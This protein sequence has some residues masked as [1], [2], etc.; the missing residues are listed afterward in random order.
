MPNGMQ[1]LDSGLPQFTGTE[2]TAD[3]VSA[4]QNYLFM[5]LEQLRYVLNNLGKEN[6]NSTE[7][8]SLKTEIK[9]AVKIELNDGEDMA[10]IQIDLAGLHTSIRNAEGN[11]STLEQTAEGIKSQVTDAD[12]NYTVLNLKA[13]GLHVGNDSG[14]TN[15]DGSSINAGSLRLTDNITFTNVRDSALYAGATA[16]TADAIARALANGDTLP[17]GVG[18]FINGRSIYSPNIYSNLLTLQPPDATEEWSGGLNMRGFFGGILYDMLRIAYEENL[19]PYVVMSSPD[20]AYLRIRDFGR[21]EVENRVH[22]NAPIE[23]V[24]YGTDAPSG[25][26]NPGQLYFQIVS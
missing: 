25:L 18:T 8:E 11:I 21:I 2:N 15:I 9:N 13:D 12:G 6:F 23:T 3:K 24:S 20:N 22:F 16:V 17:S 26:A 5:L 4:I 19:A 1:M 14:T 10:T 7:L